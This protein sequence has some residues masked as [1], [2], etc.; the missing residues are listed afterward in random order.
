M[1][2]I[3]EKKGYHTSISQE[4]SHDHTKPWCYGQSYFILY[5]VARYFSTLHH[6]RR[7]I[8]V[9]QNIDPKTHTRYIPGTWY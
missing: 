8:V 7:M 3:N 5:Q 1:E 4:C 9:L 2:R 6:T